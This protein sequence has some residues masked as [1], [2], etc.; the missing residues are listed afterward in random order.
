MSGRSGYSR[1]LPVTTSTAYAA[2]IAR[3]SDEGF[4]ATVAALGL[5]PVRGRLTRGEARELHPRDRHA[6]R[7][8][9][10]VRSVRAPPLAG[11]ACT[12]TASSTRRRT[13]KWSATKSLR[14]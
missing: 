14:S 9:D 4:I 12:S 5:Q 8:L 3:V 1:R 11:V 2:S 10:R 13:T 6:R 7:L